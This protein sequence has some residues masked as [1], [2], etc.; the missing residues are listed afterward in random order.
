MVTR[1]PTKFKLSGQE[2]LNITMQIKIQK[3][4]KK[5]KEK[6]SQKSQASGDSSILD[7]S[8]PTF[9]DIKLPKTA[10]I[11]RFGRDPKESLAKLK[12]IHGFIFVGD[13]K[14]SLSLYQT[15]LKISQFMK[16]YYF[17]ISIIRD[18][19]IWL[20]NLLKPKPFR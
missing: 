6:F 3:I 7:S 19:R 8:G 14:V 15:I 2:A 10:K 16:L 1:K 13:I 18:V 4:V 9:E 12:K 20:S 11:F 5:A 17:I